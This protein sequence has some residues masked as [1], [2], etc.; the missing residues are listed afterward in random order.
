MGKTYKDYVEKLLT[1]KDRIGRPETGRN[2]V[3]PE[4]RAALRHAA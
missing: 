3:L 2:T 4:R 1:E